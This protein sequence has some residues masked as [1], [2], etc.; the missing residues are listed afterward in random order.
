MELAAARNDRPTFDKSAIMRRA[1]YHARFALELV[2]ARK[3]GAAARF[4]ALSR[5]LRKAWAEAKMEAAE[6]ARRA[7][8]DIATLARLANAARANAALA[9]EYGNSR[10]LILQAIES[11]RM[12]DRMDFAAIDRLRAALNC[13]GA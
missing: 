5:A 10:P 11:E 1:A 4:A 13:I 8:L 6:L 12:R 3:E 9:A 2:K 7:Q